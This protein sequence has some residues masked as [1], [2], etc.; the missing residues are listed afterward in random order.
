MTETDVT[1]PRVDEIMF[2]LYKYYN[3][4]RIIECSQEYISLSSSS[5][6]SIATVESLLT[7]TGTLAAD[8]P[9]R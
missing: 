2:L 1:D 9:R 4:N 6:S 8:I 5:S 7:I 3:S